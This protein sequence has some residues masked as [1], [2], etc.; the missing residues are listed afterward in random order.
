MLQVI[1][2]E[3]IC[4]KKNE[5][6]IG[7]FNIGEKYKLVSDINSEFA[8]LLCKDGYIVVPSNLVEII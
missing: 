3:K 2:K 4:Y 5:K 1:I 7:E 6:Q 8:V